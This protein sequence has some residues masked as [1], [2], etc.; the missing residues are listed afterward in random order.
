MVPSIQ[1]NTE[2]DTDTNLYV[3]KDSAYLVLSKDYNPGDTTITV[4]LDTE[5]TSLFPTTGIITLVEQCSDP[6]YRA[7]SFYY[8]SRTDT[9]FSGLTRLANTPDSYK[10]SRQT[11]VVMNVMAE[12]H[13]NIKDAIIAIQS[14]VGKKGLMGSTSTV[15]TG[16]LE[17]RTNFLIS[18]AFEPKAW[19][20]VNKTIGLAPFTVTFSNQSVRLGEELPNNDIMFYWDF[21]DNT[22]SNITYYQATDV[23]PPNVENVIVEDL[24]SGTIT[25]T[26]TR[27]GTY[28]VK[29]TVVNDYGSDTVEFTNLINAKYEAPDVAVV[30]FNPTGYQQCFPSASNCQYFKT[31][32]NTQVSIEIPTGINPATGRTYSGEEVDANDNPIDPIIRYTWLL[33]DDTSHGNDQT[34]TALYTIGGLKDLVVRC[35]TESQAFRITT[36]NS[37]IDVVERQNLWLSTFFSNSTTVV[38][39]SEFGLISETFKSKQSQTTTLDISTSFL[40]SASNATQLI[41]EFKRNT[42]F[43]SK[44]NIPSGLSGTAIIHYATGRTSGNPTDENIKALDYNGYLETYAA[45]QTINRPWNWVSLSFLNK[46]Y[47]IFGNLST[48]QAPGTSLTNLLMQ[49][50]DLISNTVL[51]STFSAGAFIGGA[52]QLQSNAAEFESGLPIYGNFSAYRTA[53]RGR[54]GYILKNDGVGEF[55]RI[56]SFFSTSPSASAAIAT[57]NKLPDMLGPTK[58]EGQLVNLNSGLFFFNNTGAIS[59]FNTTDGVWKTGGPGLNSSVFTSLQDTTVNGYENDTN[60]LLATT[61]GD[62]KAYLSFDYTTKSFLKFNDLDVTFT[63]LPDRPS[64]NQWTM[65]TF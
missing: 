10:P 30:N 43:T 22:A 37:Y 56:R 44:A 59:S 11:T 57:F 26:Y 4:E 54:S 65:G 21:G 31:P 62:R 41:R 5:K 19:F 16:K 34:T 60:T 24:D 6:Q 8:T 13:N 49:E 36:Y 15:N 50:H 45:Y 18:R 1:F 9:V 35:D 33:S 48:A 25:K 32:T 55:F 64:G 53:W 61:D 52:T 46:T 3:V 2:Y 14:F 27:P 51:T 39:N 29:L 40:Q 58:V 20:T 28:T 17:E 47:F 7:V 42:S 63:K 12:H 38:Q 23:V